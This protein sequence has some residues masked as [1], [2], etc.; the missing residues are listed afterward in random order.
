M[1]VDDQTWK[2]LS[3]DSLERD[4]AGHSVRLP[5]PERLPVFDKLQKRWRP[6]L[7][8]WGA[9]MDETEPLRQYYLDHFDTPEKRLRGKNPIPFRMDF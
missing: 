8:D 1:F 2:T 4:I 3:A 6:K 7:V 9:V 5:Q